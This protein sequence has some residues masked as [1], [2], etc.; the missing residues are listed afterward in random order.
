MNSRLRDEFCM[1]PLSRDEVSTCSALLSQH[2]SSRLVVMPTHHI[3]HV[4]GDLMGFR[5]DCPPHASGTALP[6]VRTMFHGHTVV[7]CQA[8]EEF[9]I[10]FMSNQEENR[11]KMR[12]FLAE[13]EIQCVP[14]TLDCIPENANAVDASGSA[15]MS[16]QGMRSMDSKHWTPEVPDRIGFYHA[17]IRGFN[18]DVRTHKMFICCSGGLYKAC[19][20]FCNLMIDV[21]QYWT[22]NEVCESEEAWWLRKGCQRSRCRLIK[23]LADWFGV[24]VKVIHDVQAHNEDVMQAVPTTD[25]VEHDMVRITEP[26]D[27]KANKIAVYNLC[28]DTTARNM[29]GILCSMHPSEWVH[30]TVGRRCLQH[31]RKLAC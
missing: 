27:G 30:R 31:H 5:Y 10:R 3:H 7:E 21:G 20:Q 9:I 2:E 15:V 22:A 26:G 29:N 6:I 17:Y 13:V 8:S 11:R 4:T 24:E 1:T 18:R 19:D 14:A 28:T 16:V 23:S 12:E 25:T